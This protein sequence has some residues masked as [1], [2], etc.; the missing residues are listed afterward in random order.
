MYSKIFNLKSLL[1]IFKDLAH[2]NNHILNTVFMYLSGTGDPANWVKF[3][4][5]SFA[6]G[7]ITIPLVYLVSGKFFSQKLWKMITVLFAAV[8]FPLVVYS[9]EAR[10]Y[11]CLVL[12]TMLSFYLLLEYLDKR[13]KWALFCFHV[14]FVL[15]VLSHFSFFYV[16]AGLLALAIYCFIKRLH[17]VRP[18]ELF[19]IFF[20]PVLAVFI[21]CGQFIMSMKFG[22]GDNFTV[23]QVVNKVTALLVGLPSELTYINIITLVVS[24]GLIWGLILLFKEKP[25]LAV[26]ITSIIAVIF[27]HLLFRRPTHIFFRYFLCVFPFLIITMVYVLR[28]LYNRGGIG[29][30]SAFILAAA[31]L[32]GNLA[33]DINFLSL[34][35]GHYFDA[36]SYM[37]EHSNNNT[38]TVMGDHDFR[39]SMLLIFYDLFYQGDKQLA[40]FYKDDSPRTGSDWFIVHK[41]GRKPK[42]PET[43]LVDKRILYKKEKH[44]PYNGELS[45]FHW[46]IYRRAGIVDK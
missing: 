33:G 29:K 10:G 39:N 8:S 26:F 43:I 42:V 12:F 32:A 24:S 23:L 22:G 18:V 40:Y 27:A 9:S 17:N 34:G 2:D 7:I 4:L 28:K 3:R 5:L 13:K 36:L 20:L 35:R 31:I 45:G 41:T 16:A 37:Y 11:A 19:K 15:G 30:I 44:Y 46:F 14:S 1:P 25:R 21:L 6:G 38:V